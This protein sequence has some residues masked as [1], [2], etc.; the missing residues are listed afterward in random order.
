MRVPAVLGLARHY[1]LREW[2]EFLVYSSEYSSITTGVVIA[3]RGS[4]IA[5]IT[6]LITCG[7]LFAAVLGVYSGSRERCSVRARDIDHR[8]Y[9]IAEVGNQKLRL[10]CVRCALTQGQQEHRSVRLIA[11]TGYSSGRQIDPGAAWFVEG[12]RAIECEHNATR[13]NQVKRPDRLLFDRCTPSTVAFLNHQDAEDF[14]AKNGGLL[15]RLNDLM[16]PPAQQ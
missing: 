14:I 16:P 11:V 2:G 10:C 15:R 12:S 8:L 7:A 3:K 4:R 5:I 9:A 1:V 6:A 13:I